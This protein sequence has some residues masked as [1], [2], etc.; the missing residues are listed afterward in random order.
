MQEII[1]LTEHKI[2][3]YEYLWQLAR[4]LNQVDN[5]EFYNSLLLRLRTSLKCLKG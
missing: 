2:K 3:E 5:M 4:S 1:E